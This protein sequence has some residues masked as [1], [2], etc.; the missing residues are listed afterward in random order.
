MKKKILNI[1]SIVL[2]VTMLFSLTGCSNTTNNGSSD[3]SNNEGVKVTEVGNLSLELQQI[4][5][6]SE[7]L[8]SA[9]KDGKWGF[10]DKKGN[11]VIDFIYEYA[12]NFLEGLASVKKDGKAGYINAKGEVI[13]DFIYSSTYAFSNGYGV[14]KEGIYY[15][16]V[17][18]EGNVV[19]EPTKYYNVSSLT[20]DLFVVDGDKGYDII[21][22]SGEIIVDGTAR[23]GKFSDGLIPVKQLYVNGKADMQNGKWGFLDKSGNIVIDYQYD[24]VGTFV[25]GI[26]G[27]VKEGK[28][29]Y[30]NTKG[31]YVI[32]AQYPYEDNT[33]LR[34]YSC[35]IVRVYDGEKSIYFDESGNQVFTL[36][37]S[38]IGEFNEDLAW[39]VN[40]EDD[41]RGYVNTKGKIVID[42]KYTRANNFSDGL[43]KV[44]TD[45]E[46]FEFINSK[47]KTILAGKI[48]K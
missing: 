11:V 44:Y 46:S 10:I 4:N 24:Y 43:A 9:K 32:E 45:D 18:K 48:V 12:G 41:K 2:L 47:G 31:E 7:G 8:A 39:V 13:V 3:N 14:I 26:A 1:I 29:G 17:D 5:D 35:G 21:N 28:I 6:F 36:E 22:K 30:I 40:N 37:N 16:A 38:T 20:N 33:I 42:Y 15:G 25:N 19:I 34:D 23:V 27:V